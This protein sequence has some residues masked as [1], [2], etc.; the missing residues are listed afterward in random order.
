[1]SARRYV[2]GC[3]A[4]CLATAATAE[5]VTGMAMHGEPKYK[6]GFAAVEYANPNAPKGGALSLGWQGSFD[7]L[8][9]YSA[10]DVPPILIGL[11]FQELGDQT[12]DEAFTMYG[13]VAQSFEIAPDKLSMIVNLNPAAKFSDGK[14]V[15]AADVAFSFKI[16]MSDKATT[17]YR[18]YYSDIKDVKAVGP[19]KVTM[20]FAK[21]NPELP[22][23]ALQ[24]PVL[25][26]H[27]YGKGDFAKDFATKAVGSGPY[28][29]KDFKPGAYVTYKRNPDFWGKDL[30]LYK[31]RYNL[32]EI[33]VKYFKDPT[34]QV[35]SFKKGDYDFFEVYS[36]KQWATDLTGERF[37]RL[38]W[39]TKTNW[40]H[41]N[42]EGSQGFMF[43]LR[44][45]KFEDVRVRQA[46]AL[47]FDFDWAN[48]NLFYGQYKASDSYFENSPLK[49]TGMPPPE[50]LA[51]LEPLKADLPADVF[52]KE[53]GWLGKGMDIKGR[54]RLAMQLLKDA[55]YEVK[56]G[57]ATGKAGPLQL[58]IMMRGEGFQ[59]IVEPYAQNLKR[60]G[61]VLTS[62]VKETSVYVR[63]LESRAFDM[64]V[65]SVGQS[66]SP[67]NEQLEMW[68]SKAADEKNTRNY[69]GVKNKGIDVL[70]DKIIHAKDR[71]ELEVATRALDRVLYH[72]HLQVHNWYADS[73]R[74]AMW[75][76]FG[77]TDA[78]PLFYS[79]RQ[80]L[81][82]AWFDAD[83][84]KRLEEARK[85]NK[86]L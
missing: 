3:V 14:P 71:K 7:T 82:F 24:L 22:L 66:Q 1:M 67:G 86:P 43:N 74:V 11:V 46:I 38:R 65:M 70:I 8:N 31:G 56:G 18:F 51:L 73:H 79:P 69:A 9:P 75:D 72:L 85:A 10:K 40:Q 34:A 54:M 16:L 15:T 37:E 45:P 39:I 63:D 44:N 64:T 49:A 25:P 12:L 23:I 2:L 28:T 52:S 33:T 68:G 57:V 78:T 32:D 17:T 42:N 50:E 4:S 48:K 81:E 59:R 62:D 53:V 41:K 55:G 26:E 19:H 58:K 84:A 27:V 47:A 21:V 77:V 60:V 76:K 13:A 35:E 5:P 80:R 36:A 20:T 61:V 83:K 6:P 30:P 29:V